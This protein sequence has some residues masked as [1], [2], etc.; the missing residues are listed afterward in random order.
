MYSGNRTID[1]VSQV[2]CLTMGFT[3]R[4]LE[5]SCAKT[6][7]KPYRIVM[8]GLTS[9]EKQIPRNCWKHEKARVKV[10]IVGTRARAC[11]AGA[12]PDELHMPARAGRRSHNN[13]STQMKGSMLVFE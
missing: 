5:L 8:S 12:L 10:G 6:V 2:F 3:R 11:K 13:Y 9:S 4:V 7:P 1:T